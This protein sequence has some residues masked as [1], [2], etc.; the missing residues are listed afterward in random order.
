MPSA[1]ID[2]QSIR[3]FGGSQNHAFEELCAQLANLEPRAAGDVF[4]RKGIGADAGVECFM[5]HK[6]GAETGWQAKYFF[7]FGSSQVSQLDESIE[8]ALTKHPRLTRFIVCIPFELRDE[9]VGQA[10]TQ[11]QR[12]RD[13]VKKWKARAAKKKRK[14]SL[15][16][17]SKSALVERLGRND[18]LYSG[19]VA[20]WFDETFL[21]STWF[22]ERLS[23]RERGSV[24]GIRQR[25][26]SN[27][28]LGGAFSPSAVIHRSSMKS[29]VGA[30]SSKKHGTTPFGI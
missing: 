9:R 18:P 23:A 12:W 26:T 4:Y 6:S 30:R 10:K 3:S 22:E 16:L 2:F 15:E 28:R 24:S 27:C 25:R 20:F 19:R 11:L 5:R 17:W 14:L 8:Q 21:A 1:S 29:N 7:D 13:W